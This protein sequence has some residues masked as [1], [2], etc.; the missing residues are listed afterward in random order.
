MLKK[1]NLDAIV[2]QLEAFSKEVERKL[3]GMV[4]NFSVAVLKESS[5]NTRLGDSEKNAKLYE[6]RFKEEGWLPIEGMAQG[7]WVVSLNGSPTFVERHGK[8]GTTGEAVVAALNDVKPYKLG[9]NFVIG[10]AVPYVGQFQEEI[11]T[12]TINQITSVIQAD[13]KSFYDKS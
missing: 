5:E 8:E 12:P 4:Q 7:G 13:L 1:S 9:Q 11:K 3:V 10:N 6:R 2:K